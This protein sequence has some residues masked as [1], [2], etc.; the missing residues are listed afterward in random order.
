MMRTIVALT[1]LMTA[2]AAPSF[3]QTGTSPA[4]GVSGT[5]S[6]IMLADHTMRASKL[7]GMAV[8]NNQGE[9][10][11]TIDDILVTAGAIEPTVVVSVGGFLGTGQRLATEPLSHVKLAA[12]D[13]MMM[14]EATKAT[15]TAKPV[16]NYEYLPG[17]SGG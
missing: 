16:F 4:S 17:S 7:I 12:G 8:Y 14:P 9:K 15:I 5:H 2:F 13:K 10:V 1:A 6:G 11:G 3:A